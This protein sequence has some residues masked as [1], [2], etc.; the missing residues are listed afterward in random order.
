[1]ICF[2]HLRTFLTVIVGLF[3]C[4][5]YGQSNFYKTAKL[6]ASIVVKKHTMGAELVEITVLGANYPQDALAEKLATLGQEL[7]T[8]PWGIQYSSEAGQFI[9]VGFACKG[10]ITADV[11]KFNIAALARSMAFGQRPIKCFS[12]FFE[13][14][15]P[16]AA[17]P[18]GWIQKT[19]KFDSLFTSNPFGIEYRIQVDTD[20]PADI[21]I[22][23]NPKKETTPPAEPKNQSTFFVFGGII[24]GAIAIGLLVYSALLRPRRP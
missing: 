9:K 3:A 4:W 17:T 6:E 13:G 11:P 8:S 16:D 19:W 21:F 10:L 5:S 20:N 24:I 23:G 2:K 22:G 15:K 7:K 1:M 18:G 12:V 14:Y